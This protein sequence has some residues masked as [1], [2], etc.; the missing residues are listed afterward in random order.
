MKPIIAESC[1]LSP[2]RAR[3]HQIK[4]TERVQ[5]LPLGVWKTIAAVAYVFAV[6]VEDCVEVT[7]SLAVKYRWPEPL[8]LARQLA[9]QARADSDV[10]S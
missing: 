7:T 4:L 3:Q 8:R 1:Q 2:Q 10:D 5:L 6:T 9:R